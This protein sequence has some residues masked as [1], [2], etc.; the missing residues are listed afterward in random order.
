MSTTEGPP[1][2]LLISFEGL[3]GSGKT[4]QIGR[5]AERLQALGREVV[6]AVEPG[7]T[8]IGEQIR[9]LLLD[10][11]HHELTP[12]TEMLLYFASRAQNVAEV[13]RPALGR[14]AIVLAD[15]FTDS[16]MAYQGYG[17]GL[18]ARAVRA[19]HR[20][21]C[22]DL[23]PDLT[24][25][26]DVDPEVGL[27]RAGRRGSPNRMDV[28]AMDFYRRVREAYRRMA[29]RDPLRMRLL[30]GHPGPEAVA[31]A[32]WSEVQKALGPRLGLAVGQRD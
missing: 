22:G 27:A 17:R 26:L 3:D 11:R 12:A 5:L 23:Q 1:K 9:G 2:G 31:A 4:T 13:I 32:V 16:T 8:R 25:V 7:G 21:A 24:L 10:A 19:L 28:Q 14:G 15:R 6:V 30:D 20:I 29:R 18:G